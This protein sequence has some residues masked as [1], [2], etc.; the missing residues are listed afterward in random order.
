MSGH[1]LI[2]DSE[3]SEDEEE[4]EVNWEEFDPRRSVVLI[5]IHCIQTRY[6]CMYMLLIHVC[7]CY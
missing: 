1:T 3:N 6:I 5:R 7:T 2:P 4:L